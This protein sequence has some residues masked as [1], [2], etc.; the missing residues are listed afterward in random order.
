MEKQLKLEFITARTYSVS[1]CVCVCV[2]IHYKVVYI[3]DQWCSVRKV[4]IR[5]W[6]LPQAS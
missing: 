5:R 3:H 6:L 2:L 4:C 1:V